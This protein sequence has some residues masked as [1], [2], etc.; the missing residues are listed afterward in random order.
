VTARARLILGCL[1]A[2]VAAPTI[3]AAAASPDPASLVLRRADIGRAYTGHGVRLDNVDAAR[4][5]PPGFAARLARWG[6][7]DGYQVDFA[8]RASLATLQNGPLE[9]QSSASVYRSAS[10]ARAA[11]TY[12]HRQLVPAG[13]VPLALGFAVGDQARQWVRQAASGL[14]AMIQ[15]LLIWRTRNIDASITVTG[16]IGVVSAADLAQLARRQE[17]HIRAAV[18]A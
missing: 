2:A 4:G 8:R 18:V 7:I 10:G 5:A 17:T 15:Y 13:Y 12:A 3:A 16:R 11:F 1:V 6:R 9:V 14:G